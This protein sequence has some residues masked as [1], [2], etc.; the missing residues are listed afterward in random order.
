MRSHK[1]TSAVTAAAVLLALA[2]AGAAAARTHSHPHR[3]NGARSGICRVTLRVA[4]RLVTAGETVLA[5]GTGICGG[6]AEAGQTVTVYERAA[7]SGGYT[8]AGTT[9]TDSHGD[10]QVTTT[11]LTNNAVFYATVG[12]GR[13]QMRSVRV[14]AQVTLAGPPEGKQL[15]AGIRTGR[16][17]AVTFTGTVSPDDAGAIVVLQRE[18]A[19]R[20]NEW[21][22]IGQSIVNSAGGFALTHVFRAPGASDIRVLVRSNHRN[23]ASPSNVLSYIISQAQNPSLTIESSADPIA[24]G[25][26]TVISG[27]VAGAPGTAVTLYGHTRLG[28]TALAT[29]TTNPEG[30]YAFPAQKPAISTLYQVKGAGR[31]SS[32]LYE[33]VKFILT[34]A[35]AS[36][37][38]PSGQPVTFTGTVT[39]VVAGHAIYIERQNAGGTGFH[40]AA[41]GS[42]AADGTYSISR[43]FYA[44]G[45]DVLRVK[46]PG[47]SEYGG[48]ASPTF[49]VTI[50]P[51]PSAAAIG[52]EPS[53][54]GSL[55]P[56]GQL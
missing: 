49:D 40:V 23:I 41:V 42:V 24:A 48:T 26:T 3:R 35:P 2:T 51:L 19:V 45:V 36:L 37:S 31:S 5:Y 21:H 55:P 29:T 25:E 20:G 28:T 22:W 33:G 54:N 39:P 18:N 52:A 10:F 34:A 43:V 15:L 44:P 16:R 7:G 32:V 38:V 11:P 56:E 9:T 6:L 8:V 47:D 46:I 50:T 4:P 12:T 14:A 1:L 17:N 13:S 27:T 53:G 30:K